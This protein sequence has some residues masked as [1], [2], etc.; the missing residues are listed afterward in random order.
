M[1]DLLAL[2]KRYIKNMKVGLQKVE[3]DGACAK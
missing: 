3:K 2:A 1:I